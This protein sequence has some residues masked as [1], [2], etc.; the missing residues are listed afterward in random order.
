MINLFRKITL[1]LLPLILIS[2]VLYAQE[3]KH[4]SMDMKSGD[5]P[6]GIKMDDGILYGKEIN[7]DIK[8]IEVNELISSVK[9]N[10]GKIIVVK[11]KISDVCQAMGCWLV[12]TDGKN[13]VRV[14]TLHKFF[15]PKNITGQDAVVMGRF[16]IVEI[17]EDEANEY[18]S[19]SNSPS[20]ETIKGPQKSFEIIAT[21]VKVL[22][23]EKGSN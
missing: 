23:P 20:K 4:K 6:S 3:D 8:V 11:G 2:A 10:E 22:N 14:Q 18:N 7:S 19:E 16:E 1:L 5:E 13:N 9:E 12:L 21:G 15:V 17:S